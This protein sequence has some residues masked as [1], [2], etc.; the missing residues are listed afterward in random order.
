MASESIVASTSQPNSRINSWDVYGGGL[1]V[2][3]G[4]FCLLLYNI[5]ANKL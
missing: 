3:G 2:Y 1:Q 5:I 4:L